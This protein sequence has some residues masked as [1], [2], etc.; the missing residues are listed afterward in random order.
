[1]EKLKGET[2]EQKTI[3]RDKLRKQ[4]QDRITKEKKR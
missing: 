2:E 1:M 3:F 4:E